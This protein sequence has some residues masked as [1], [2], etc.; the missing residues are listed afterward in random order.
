MQAPSTYLGVNMW[1]SEEEVEEEGAIFPDSL[2]KRNLQH[3]LP[4]VIVREG[5][6]VM[7]QF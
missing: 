4:W 7:H 5:P 6:Y 2:W 1:R 3:I